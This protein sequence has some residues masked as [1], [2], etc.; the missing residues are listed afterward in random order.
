M[1]IVGETGSD[2]PVSVQ[3]ENWDFT[4]PGLVNDIPGQSFHAGDSY[5]ELKF[6]CTW[7]LSQN[8]FSCILHSLGGRPLENLWMNQEVIFLDIGLSVIKG[9]L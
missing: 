3:F 6:A 5:S 2:D 1:D 9:N 7:N 4:E 8:I